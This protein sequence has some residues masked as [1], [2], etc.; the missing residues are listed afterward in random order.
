MSFLYFK[1]LKKLNKKMKVWNA[2]C[3]MEVTL[4]NQDSY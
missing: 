4:K 3:F 1:T 2:Y